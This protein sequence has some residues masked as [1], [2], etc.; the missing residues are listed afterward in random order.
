MD[1]ELQIR[2]HGDESRPTLIYLPGLHGDW[3][4]IASFRKAFGGR[5]R[6]IEVTYPRTLTWTL[7]DYA[8]AVESVLAGN[9]IGHGWLLG[10]SFSSQV[11]WAMIARRQFQV[12]GVILAGGFVRHPL[13]WGVR[14]AKLLTSGVSLTL[15]TRILFGYAKFARFRYRHAPETRASIPEFIARR[16]ELDR[17]AATHRLSLIAQNDPRGV[18]MQVCVPV[19]A[20]AGLVDPIVPWFPVRRWLR[21]NCPAFRVAK[22]I[23]RAD[24]NVL[25]TAPDAAAEIVEKWMMSTIGDQSA[26]LPH[27]TRLKKCN[28][29]TTLKAKTIAGQSVHRVIPAAAG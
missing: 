28:V 27:G 4:L 6:F 3:T 10:E 2:I 21:K 16:T 17:Q 24:H 15:L 7:D 29:T 19:Y 1:E 13:R 20:L 14:L 5:V 12:E 11:V 9:G 18:A 25:S 23:C 22:V 26:F 8:V